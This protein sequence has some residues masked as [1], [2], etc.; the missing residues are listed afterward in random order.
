MSDLIEIAKI[1][2][3]YDAERLLDAGH[4]PNMVTA[5]NTSPAMIAAEKCDLS[6]ISLLSKRG[7][8]LNLVNDD[9]EDVLSI[10][11]RK[12]YYEDREI[13]FLLKLG[14]VPDPIR[15]RDVWL[16]FLL[17]CSRDTVRQIL[18]VQRSMLDI[19]VY[20]TK[21]IHQIILWRNAEKLKLLL[22]AGADPYEYNSMHIDTSPEC[23][24]IL[25]EFEKSFWI[26]CIGRK[27]VPVTAKSTK[28]LTVIE[29]C[30]VHL[31]P[32]LLVELSKLI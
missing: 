31:N 23:K 8:N 15:H 26:Y 1:G 32:D 25:K 3:Y 4:D 21:A 5:N 24:K 11:T 13:N 12:H 22:E 27:K 16:F 17:N 20:D 7:A 28:P 10:Y 29:Y 9:N 19:V 18:C 6:I 2:W 30:M 14:C